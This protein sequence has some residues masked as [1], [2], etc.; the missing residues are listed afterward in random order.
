[1]IGFKYFITANLLLTGIM[2]FSCNKKSTEPKPEPQIT[3]FVEHPI[4]LNFAGIHCIKVIDLDGDGDKDIVGGSEIT[5][6]S[7]SRGIS[8]WRNEGGS[9]ITWTRFTVECKF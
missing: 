9:P 8:W 1:M 6:Y 4:D 7:Q 5:P 2:M 3:N